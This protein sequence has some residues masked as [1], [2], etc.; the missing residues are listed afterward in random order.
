MKKDLKFNLRFILVVWIFILII[1][2][3]HTKNIYRFSFLEFREAKGTIKTIQMDYK[4]HKIIALNNIIYGLPRGVPFYHPNRIN[5]LIKSKVYQTYSIKNVKYL[6]DSRSAK[7]R[8]YDF[9]EKY[10]DFNIFKNNDIFLCTKDKDSNLKEFSFYKE[11]FHADNLIDL[12]RK[13]DKN[14]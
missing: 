5:K 2:F 3:L 8:V 13:I 7:F 14:V 10:K 6:I 9:I 12:K 1:L 4:E 11:Y